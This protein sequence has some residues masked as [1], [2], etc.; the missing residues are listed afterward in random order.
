M[1]IISVSLSDNVCSAMRWFVF[2]CVHVSFGTWS[3]WPM[4]ER[5]TGGCPCKMCC[6]SWPGRIGCSKNVESI[7]LDL[8]K[9]VR[10]CF[11]KSVFS[12]ISDIASVMGHWDLFCLPLEGI[13]VWCFA[14]RC[15]FRFASDAVT[16]E[17]CCVRVRK[18]V[19]NSFPFRCVHWRSTS[20]QNS[21]VISRI[22]IRI[23]ERSFSEFLKS[24]YDIPEL[25]GQL[26]GWLA[27]CLQT[28]LPVLAWHGLATSIYLSIY[29][30]IIYIYLNV[31]K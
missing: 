17:R 28:N 30:Y 4:R 6:C 12:L 5:T 25:A 7:S 22:H 16:K 23:L 14:S 26:V 8:A 21:N 13:C 31:K 10:A 1:E 18:S 11:C 27:G 2:A 3:H 9:H 24:E 20:V 15:A 29:L 19:R